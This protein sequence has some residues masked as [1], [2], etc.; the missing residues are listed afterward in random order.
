M[1]IPKKQDMQKKTLGVNQEPNESDCILLQTPEKNK[2][3][4]KF[5]FINS[6]DIKP[7]KIAWLIHGFIALGSSTVL[8]GEP[9]IGKTTLSAL[10]TSWIIKGQSDFENIEVSVK[11][12]VMWYSSEDAPDTILIPRL[13]AAGVDENQRKQIVFIKMKSLE[14]PA[15]WLD[16][17]FREV[18]QYYADHPDSNLRAIFI[19]PIHEFIDGDLNSAKDV[20]TNM[21]K[22]AQFAQEKNL[23]IIGIHHFSKGTKDVR[24]I[25]RVTGSIQHVAKARVVLGAVKHNGKSYFGI[26]KSNYD[27]INKSFEYEIVPHVQRYEGDENS[28]HTSKVV[29]KEYDEY[30]SLQDILDNVKPLSKPK[31][32]QIKNAEKLAQFVQ[33]NGGVLSNKELDQQ[34]GQGKLFENPNALRSAKSCAV[35]TG[36]LTVQRTDKAAYYEFPSINS[37]EDDDE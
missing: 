4:N 22:L 30:R 1:K 25:D 29:F 23:A 27:R 13:S 9:S 5:D 28:Y 15:K 26:I 17:F 20:A 10:L 21:R 31:I 12:C 37:I 8:A 6:I 18:E 33:E 11:G 14:S 7:K 34:V 24:L 19:D 32:K 36:L 3:L 16:N 2:T 35:E